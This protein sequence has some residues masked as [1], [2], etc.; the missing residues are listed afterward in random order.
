MRYSADVNLTTA[1]GKTALM[2]TI[3]AR[4]LQ[5]IH[6]FGK[7]VHSN[8]SEDGD[9]PLISYNSSSINLMNML[10][11]INKSSSCV[12][13]NDTKFTSST[14]KAIMASSH[15][16]HSD[17][18]YSPEG[19]ITQQPI[20]LANHPS[21]NL[22]APC[23]STESAD[24]TDTSTNPLSPPQKAKKCY[25]KYFPIQKCC[26]KLCVT[27]I[28]TLIIAMGIMLFKEIIIQQIQFGQTDQSLQMP[29]NSNRYIRPMLKD[30][31][32]LKD[33]ITFKSANGIT[34]VQAIE[35]VARNCKK[36]GYM[37]DLNENSVQNIWYSG[38]PSSITEKCEKTIEIWL[39][40]Q[41]ST[42]VT[43]ETFIAA[44]E[45]IGMMELSRQLQNTY[46]IKTNLN[47][48]L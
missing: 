35:E 36:L 44:L 32:K 6:L 10:K 28:I 43:W 3:E 1:Q 46:I 40:G 21:T 48:H 42:P 15:C 8:Y 11:Q 7:L 22:L 20:Y 4:H 26:S 47:T 14:H 41:G 38:D 37:L 12:T 34:S 30:K 17:K 29:P 16:P 13:L 45:E 25:M 24:S 23:I 5:V 27:A 39:E 33:L 19:Q 18:K 31:P 2:I 9:L